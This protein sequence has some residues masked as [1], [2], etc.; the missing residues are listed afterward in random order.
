L[1]WK[2]KKIPEPVLVIGAAL[3]GLVVYP[4]VSR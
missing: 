2:F 3:I 4:I 1:L